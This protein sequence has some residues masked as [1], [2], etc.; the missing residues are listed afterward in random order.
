MAIPQVTAISEARQVQAL[1]N[2]LLQLV[3]QVG[4]LNQKCGSAMQNTWKAFATAPLDTDGSLGAADGSP[5]N[6]N[7]MTIGSLGFSAND[8]INGLNDLVLVMN[9]VS[10][11]SNPGS[12]V[13]HRVDALTM[14]T[15]V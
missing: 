11:V 1:W 7:P 8:C 15:N 5:N 3:A 12:V 6:A 13:D 10:G 14:T 4:P 2:Q 9:M